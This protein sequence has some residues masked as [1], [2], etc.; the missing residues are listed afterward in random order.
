MREDSTR[1]CVTDKDDDIDRAIALSLAE[2]ESYINMSS[3]ARNH[4]YVGLDS[5]GGSGG[6]LH[7][8]EEFASNLSTIYPSSV[9]ATSDRAVT[10]NAR[11]EQEYLDYAIALSLQS[12]TVASSPPPP[13]RSFQTTPMPPKQPAAAIGSSSGS[14][15]LESNKDEQEYLDYAIALSLH[16]A[17]LPSAGAPPSG[18][19]SSLKQSAAECIIV[20]SDDSSDDETVKLDYAIALSL[21]ETDD[22]G[23]LTITA[24]VPTSA[25]ATSMMSSNP[26]SPEVRPI[27]HCGL[28]GCRNEAKRFGFCCEKHRAKASRRNMLAPPNDLIERVFVGPSGDWS[29]HLLKKSHLEVRN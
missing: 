17:A 22:T 16:D 27:I 4:K 24:T 29:A 14:A 19:S 20:Y 21:Q 11:D 3:T 2:D 10:W 15:I 8:N 6:Y 13:V 5:L 26:L 12:A 25:A 18:A 9:S 1:Q 28:P 7:K 23:G